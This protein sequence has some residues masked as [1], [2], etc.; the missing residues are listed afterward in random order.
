MIPDDHDILIRLD[1]KMDAVLAWEQEHMAKCHSV[2]DKHDVRITKLEEW[3]WKE[4]GALALL[5]L[6]LQYGKEVMAA[7]FG[8]K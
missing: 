1:E 3:R 2:H 7:W 4:V 8:K 6:C 5:V